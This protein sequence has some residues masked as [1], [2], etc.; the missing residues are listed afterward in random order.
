MKHVLIRALM[1]L[2]FAGRCRCSRNLHRK[3]I[4]RRVTKA[5]RPR[6]LRRW[7]ARVRLQERNRLRWSKVERNAY[8]ALTMV[9]RCRCAMTPTWQL[10]ALDLGLMLHSTMEP[11][12]FCTTTE[13]NSPHSL[14]DGWLPRARAPFVRILLNAS[15]NSVLKML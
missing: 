2:L 9:S 10:S 3:C 13:R 15:R 7:A 12:R 14:V 8:M 1:S 11:F 5:T 4:L 6:R